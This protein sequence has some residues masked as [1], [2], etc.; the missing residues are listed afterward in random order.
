MERWAVLG[1]LFGDLS[2]QNSLRTTNC[3]GQPVSLG[4]FEAGVWEIRHPVKSSIPKSDDPPTSARTIISCHPETWTLEC[5]TLGGLGFE[6]G[7]EKNRLQRTDVGI[8][9]RRKHKKGSSTHQ[10]NI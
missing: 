9:L 2:G 8:L 1:R 6:T 3:E 7:K 10:H 4:G 5:H